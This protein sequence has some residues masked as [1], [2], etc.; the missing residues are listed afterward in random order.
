MPKVPSLRKPRVP[1]CSKVKKWSDLLKDPFAAPSGDVYCP[2]TSNLIACPSTKVRNY[3]TANLDGAEEMVGWLYPQGRAS[4]VGPFLSNAIVAGG[5][6]SSNQDSQV[7]PILKNEAAPIALCGFVSR[8]TSA[9]TVPFTTSPAVQ[10]GSP[11]LDGL[12]W[13][14][15]ENPFE[16]PK[17]GGDMKFRNT[18]FAIRISYV[19]KLVDT[20]GFVEFF[21]PYHW[22]QESAD[23]Y[24]VQLDTLRRD[25]SYKRF[26]FSANRT[27]TFVWSPNCESVDFASIVDADYSLPKDLFSRMMFRIK[28]IQ[29]TDIIEFEYIGF[30]EFT[31]HTTISSQTPS[32]NTVDSVHLGNAI[33]KLRG[34]MNERGPEKSDLEKLT[35]K[36]KLKAHPLTRTAMMTLPKH[37]TKSANIKS[38][39]GKI[40]KTV[41]DIAGSGIGD[42]ILSFL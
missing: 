34:R 37:V 33:S 31:G 14:A 17:A 32:E 11:K 8:R 28:G 36:G 15:L 4:S 38:G 7:G 25:P 26:Y 27:V 19:G 22:P 5:L 10:T 39:V 41:S 9:L 13:D 12:A 40:A 20:E 42:M 18:A 6:I 16:V 23:G 21:N 1:V 3:G 2:I 30:Q 24:A 29:P 35:I